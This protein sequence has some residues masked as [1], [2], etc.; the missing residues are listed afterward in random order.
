MLGRAEKTVHN[1]A[2]GKSRHPQAGVNPAKLFRIWADLVILEH[3]IVLV[4]PQ[5]R[6]RD[7][8]ENPPCNRAVSQQWQPFIESGELIVAV[9]LQEGLTNT[10]RSQCLSGGSRVLVI[11]VGYHV[12]H[13]HREG[14]PS[15]PESSSSGPQSGASAREYRS[16][17]TDFYLV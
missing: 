5:V 1:G 10:G 2:V 9:S 14:W 12:H 6:L 17:G 7:D 13:T 3:L 4:P 16:L 15:P 11:A 8:G